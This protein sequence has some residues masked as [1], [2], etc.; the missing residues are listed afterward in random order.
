MMGL[1]I[2]LRRF[3]ANSERNSADAIPTGAPINNAPPAINVVPASRGSMPKLGSLP[4]GTH[5]DPV[6]N[7]KI[8]TSGAVKKEKD[9]SASV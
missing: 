6:K 7:S 1:R 8:F 9:P 2:D 4:L 3:P 5:R